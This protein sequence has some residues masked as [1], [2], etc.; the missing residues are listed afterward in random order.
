MGQYGNQPD[1]AVIM[2]DIAGYP[3]TKINQSAIYVGEL[4][5][6]FTQGKLTVTPA[7][8]DSVVTLTGIQPGSFLPVIVNKI[9]SSPDN[10]IPFTSILLYN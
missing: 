4:A 6:G 1:F 5:S 10:S 8:Q 3:K 9:T 7:G 2:N